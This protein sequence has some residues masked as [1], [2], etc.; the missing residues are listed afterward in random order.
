MKGR[1]LAVAGSDSGGGAGI[2]A[3][4]KTI[5]ALGAY[6]A[7]AITALTAQNTQGVQGILPVA[8]EFV[9]AQMAA[10]LDDI[11]ADCIK[12]GML[13]DQGV[14]EAVAATLEEK[15]ADVP[16]VVDPVMVSS[17]GTRLLDARATDALKARL[18]ARAR[19]VTPNAPEA[20]ALAG[21]AVASLDDMRR[22]ADSILA[23]GAAAVVVTG[24]HV[25][26]P[27]VRD[28]V[29]AADGS[30]VIEAPRIATRATHGT[31]CTFASAVAASLAQG[32]GLK[33]A[34]ERAQAFV[35][36]AMAAAPVL[37]H[38]AGPLDHAAARD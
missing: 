2:Q 12:T 27:T 17:S 21:L 34:V 3:D 16:L 1:V 8:P 35:R 38:G 13:V 4:I 6:A 20:A 5:A 31:G 18:I 24:G 33:P 7:T 15:A 37:G 11:G 22:A 26:G 23:L 29:A 30:F 25:P 14:I 36:R 28:L 10:V 32:L 9:R 19:V